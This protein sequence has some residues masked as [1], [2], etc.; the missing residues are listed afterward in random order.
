M[1]RQ[2]HRP[3]R[4]KKPAPPWV[5]SNK[6]MLGNGFSQKQLRETQ[7][8]AAKDRTCPKCKAPPNVSCR[9]LN[10]IREVGFE[11]AKE[12]KFPHT[13]RIDYDKLEQAL[14]DRGYK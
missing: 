5:K 3:S 10:D 12:N 11:L 13:E 9:N 7:I 1:G 2:N 4:V 14:E 6:I 8:W